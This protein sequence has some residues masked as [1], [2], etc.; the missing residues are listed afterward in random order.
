MVEPNLEVI[1]LF[2]SISTK[3]EDGNSR[4]VD[5]AQ[6]ENRRLDNI[7]SCPFPDYA[8]FDIQSAELMVLENGMEKLSQAVVIEIKVE[9]MEAFKRQLLFGDIQTSLW[10]H[11]F[12]LHKMVDIAGRNI[13]LLG[14][15]AP[16]D[17][18]SQFLWVDAVFVCD[19]FKLNLYTP[20]HLL[21]AAAILHEVYCSYDLVHLFV[22]AHDLTTRSAF[23]EPYRGRLSEF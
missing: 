1:E 4:V 9:F 12:A 7:N 10:H 16:A 15:D 2:A 21:R 8:N 19:F 18:M 23:A 6:I 22:D 17:A 20:E 3:S 14:T 11:G 5:R 13:R